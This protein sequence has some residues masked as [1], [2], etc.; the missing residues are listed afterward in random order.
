M[1]AESGIS[2]P[3]PIINS[4]FGVSCYY[5]HISITFRCVLSGAIDADESDEDKQ[6]GFD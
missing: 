4:L 1:V 3:T 2:Q 5:I 6:G